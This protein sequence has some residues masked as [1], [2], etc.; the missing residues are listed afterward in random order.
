M[1]VRCSARRISQQV[2]NFSQNA[3]RTVV[4]SWLCSDLS[5]LRRPLLYTRPQTKSV[6]SPGSLRFLSSTQLRADALSSKSSETKTS[7]SDATEPS[8]LDLDSDF[9]KAFMKTTLFRKLS[10]DT[11]A[12]KEVAEFLKLLE[13]KGVNPASGQS[14]G[15]MQMLKLVSDAELR[16]AAK[17]LSEVLRR[18]DIDLKSPEVMGE[19]MS[20]KKPS[21]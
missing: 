16:D 20:L 7:H 14:L 19:L 6:T 11:A 2:R 18:L 13:S 17:R 1:L 3:P 9:A 10:K 5:P 12:V 21:A 8:T 4:L 15:T